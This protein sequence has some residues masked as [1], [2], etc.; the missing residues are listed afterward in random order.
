MLDYENFLKTKQLIHPATG[1]TIA[2]ERINPHLFD[3]Q[4]VLVEWALRKGR[5]GLFATTGLGK[6]RMQLAWAEH[7]AKRVLILAPLAVTQQTVEEGHLI[8][9]EVKYVRSESQAGA[10]GIY[11]SNYEMFL[12]GAFDPSQWDAVVLD[13]ASILKNFSGKT[14][15]ALISAFKNTP[16]K[17]ECTAT[18]SPNEV[19]E[20][21]YHAD[22]L[23]VMGHRDMLTIFFTTKGTNGKYDGRFRLKNHAK[24]AFY[25][26][27]ASWAM[28]VTKPSDLGYSDAGYILPGLD[29]IPTFVESSYVPE[30]QMFLTELKGVTDRS[31]ARR[32]SLSK[33][34]EATANL[35]MAE[36]KEQWLLWTGLNDESTLLTKLLPGAVEVKGSDSPESKAEALTAFAHGEIKYLV[37]KPSIAGMGLNFQKCSRTAFVGLSDSYEDYFQAIRR[38]YRFG[39][40][41]PVTAHIV[42]S[43]AEETIY[44]NVLRKEREATKLM[45]ELVSAVK[46]FELEEVKCLGIKSDYSPSKLMQLPDWLSPCNQWEPVP[47]EG[48]MEKLLEKFEV[49]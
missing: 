32:A 34:V 9:I 20:L 1:I 31:R 3:W 11:I 18:P 14:K 23:Q 35:V 21:T 10:T 6:T 29:I 46:D 45:A 12:T 15:K 43:D 38:C 49:A 24:Q 22:F 41:R 19:V 2:L 26:W 30:G 5:A 47:L 36:P 25:R 39:Q 16:M 37:T 28:S 42:L 4:K 48:P 13:E 33:R 27:L 7:A 40:K 44:K 8:G 17:L